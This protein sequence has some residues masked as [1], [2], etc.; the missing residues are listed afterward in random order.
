MS[1]EALKTSSKGC[2]TSVC[3][4]PFLRSSSLHL[5]FRGMVTAAPLAPV[6]HKG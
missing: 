5:V 1:S 6:P 2:I 3:A 4:W